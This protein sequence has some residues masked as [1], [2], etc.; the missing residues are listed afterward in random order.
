MS[1]K[2]SI[3]FRKTAYTKQ[4]AFKPA[5]AKTVIVPPAGKKSKGS[6]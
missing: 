4:G 3:N 5:R 2:K 1:D 6:K